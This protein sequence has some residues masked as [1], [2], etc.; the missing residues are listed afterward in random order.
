[1]ISSILV[2]CILIDHSK[3][4]ISKNVPHKV[5]NNHANEKLLA[6]IIKNT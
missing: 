1:V 5:N 3:A 4:G 2:W 6:R